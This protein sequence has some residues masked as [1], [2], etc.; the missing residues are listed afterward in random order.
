[1]IL[2]QLTDNPGGAEPGRKNPKTPESLTFS[3]KSLVN[4]EQT[5]NL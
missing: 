2:I 4:S 1:M 3:A 5:N